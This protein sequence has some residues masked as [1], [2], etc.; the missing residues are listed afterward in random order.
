MKKCITIYYLFFSINFCLASGFQD[1]TK[2]QTIDWIIQKLNFYA[3]PT[4]KVGAKTRFFYDSNLDAIKCQTSFDNYLENNKMV[5]IPLKDINKIK[6]DYIESQ[7]AI[8]TQGKKILTQTLNRNGTT[9]PYHEYHDYFNLTIDYSRERDLL[10]RIG[11]AFER[12]YTFYPNES[13]A[14]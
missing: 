12:L 13:E 10:Q 5:T 9:S 7:L 8:L 4:I 2:R 14:F 6:R 1:P 3:T 11:K